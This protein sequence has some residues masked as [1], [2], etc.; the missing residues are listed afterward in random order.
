M[1][2]NSKIM[3]INLTLLTFLLFSVS[4]CCMDYFGSV[5]I[6]GINNSERDVWFSHYCENQSNDAF[7]K[8]EELVVDYKTEFILV[9]Q[10]SHRLILDEPAKNGWKGLYPNGLRFQV[11]D[12]DFIQAVGWEVFLQNYGSK[13]KPLAE[14][15]ISTK[16][17]NTSYYITYPPAH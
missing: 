6:T 9:P 16:D 1:N 3:T 12:N 10:Q 11:W 14:Y 15:T 7:I 2:P 5:S 4:S 13:Y 8:N 17:I